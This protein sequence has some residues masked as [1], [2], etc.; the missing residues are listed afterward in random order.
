MASWGFHQENDFFFGEASH[1]SSLFVSIRKVVAN[2][3]ESVR[4]NSS[5]ERHII[6]GP[7]NAGNPNLNCHGG[8]LA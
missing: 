4:I 8:H 6:V 1:M 5:S 7:K 3:S 2:S